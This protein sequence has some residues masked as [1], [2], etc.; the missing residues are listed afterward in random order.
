MLNAFLENFPR[1]K[2]TVKALDD[3]ADEY[4]CGLF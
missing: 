4:P 3:E 1:E 2:S